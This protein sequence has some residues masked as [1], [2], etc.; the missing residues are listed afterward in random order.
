MGVDMGVGMGVGMVG[1]GVG[2][3]VGMEG[4]L[5]LAQVQSADHLEALLRQGDA[6]KRRAGLGLGL[7]L[8]LGLGFGRAGYH[9]PQI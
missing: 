7:G 1:M 4:F 5:C 6:A 9:V 3:G 8:V 2:M